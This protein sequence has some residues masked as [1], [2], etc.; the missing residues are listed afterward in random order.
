MAHLGSPALQ[1][2]TLQVITGTFHMNWHHNLFSR[3]MM[4]IKYQ[5]IWSQSLGSH[6]ITL[7]FI[8]RYH[9]W[10]Y[11]ITSNEY[12]S[13]YM[14]FITF[15]T[16][17]D[18]PSY[19]FILTALQW[20]KVKS[21]QITLHLTMLYLNWGHHIMGCQMINPLSSFVAVRTASENKPVFIFTPRFYQIYIVLVI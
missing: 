3:L 4:N 17:D 7:K 16:S 21:Y 13:L 6:Y 10:R 8:K 19:W 1:P 9:V 20:H 14:Y 11:R 12:I 15:K 18:I 5:C 2:V